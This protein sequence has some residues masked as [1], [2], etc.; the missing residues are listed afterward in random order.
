[1]VTLPTYRHCKPLCRAV[2]RAGAP[3]HTFDTRLSAFIYCTLNN[4]LLNGKS[5]SAF[6]WKV[7]AAT[8]TAWASANLFISISSVRRYPN[9]ERA[10][11]CCVERHITCFLVQVRCPCVVRAPDVQICLHTLQAVEDQYQYLLGA[12][13][14]VEVEDTY[15]SG[16]L[17]HT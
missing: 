16:R 13:S 2:R 7:M 4:L 5:N 10:T 15:V 11:V 12:V 9:L 1:M 6:R 8:Y 14:C 17:F 3:T